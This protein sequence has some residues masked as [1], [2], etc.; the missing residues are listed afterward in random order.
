MKKGKRSKFF[1]AILKGNLL[2]LGIPAL[3]LAVLINTVLYYYFNSDIYKKDHVIAV[4]MQRNIEFFLSDALDTLEYVDVILENKEIE[5]PNKEIDKINSIN[6]Y[7]E[8]IEVIDKNGFVIHTLTSNLSQINYDRSGEEYFKAVERDHQIYWSRPFISPISKSPALTVALPKTDR[9]IVGYLSLDYIDLYTKEGLADL[10]R[11]IEMSILDNHG[12]YISGTEMELAKQRQL[13]SNFELLKQLSA[14]K[15][16]HTHIEYNGSESI[17]VVKHIDGPDWYLVIY[18]IFEQS[19]ET[20]NNLLRI[21]IA[22]FIVFILLFIILSSVRASRIS[23]DI[24]GFVRKTEV[25]STGGFDVEFEEQK[26]EEFSRLAD[27][28]KIMTQ[29]LKNRDAELENIAYHD[30][31]TGLRNRAYLYEHIWNVGNFKTAEVLGLIYLDIDNFKNTNDLYGHTVGDTLL[32]QTSRQLQLCVEEDDTILARLGGDEFIIL[33]ADYKNLQHIKEIIKSIRQNLREPINLGDRRIFI[34][35]SMGISTVEN[36]LGY[37]FDTQLRY[38]DTAMYVAKEQG[39]N[40]FQFFN[41]S[42]NE[43]ITKRVNIEQNLITALGNNEFRLVYQPQLYTPNGMIR[44]FEALL[45]WTSPTLGAVSP[46]EFIPIAEETGII[47]KIGEWVARTACETIKSINEMNGTD[48]IIAI[49]ASPIEL[50]N[51]N[52]YSNL[53]DIIAETRIKPEWLE[54]EITENVFVDNANEIIKT[55]DLIGGEGIKISLDDFGT[56]YSSLAYMHRLP[57]NTLK[58]DRTFIS[59]LENE[60]TSRNMV[61]SIIILA[62]KLGIF[63]IAEGVENEEQVLILNKLVCDGM[64]G[65]FYSTPLEFEKTIEYTEKKF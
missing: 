55:L 33:V 8:N 3:I 13:D 14:G 27:H 23:N 16:N 61:E 22:V 65:Y 20:V 45:R 1:N 54:I 60:K 42:M 11:G 15:D 39:K 44:G 25:I 36:G 26:Y 43:K 57:I 34:T 12:T 32:V 31:L 48:Y 41:P 63:L 56:G 40:R 30:N 6:N 59:E 10:G 53:I 62:H 7:Y 47:L 19:S 28:F 49:N 64:Q 51:S 46:T 37:D 17:A 35:V 29:N 24:N 52:Y 2:T 38:A 50:K 58:I 4:N 9:T 21:L 18:D 5:D